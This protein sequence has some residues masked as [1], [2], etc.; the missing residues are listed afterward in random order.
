M[1]PTIVGFVV[2]A[3]AMSGALFGLWLARRIPDHELDSHSRDSIKLAV[4]LIATMTALVLGLV[5]A[6]AKSTFDS[7]SEAV[8]TSAIDLLTLDRTLARY[9]PEAAEIRAELKR[10]AGI[11]LELTWPSDSSTASR[12]EVLQHASGPEEIGNRILA[13]VPAEEV[14]TQL[15]GSAVAHAERMLEARWFLVSGTS[16][17]VPLPFLAV[18]ILWIAVS[19]TI[20]G[21]LSP[22]NRTVIGAF[23]ACALSVGTAMFLILEMDGPFDGVLTVSGDPMRRAVE[24][25]GS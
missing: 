17:S 6:S 1:N 13:L 2:F 9:G 4:G 21:M 8:K 16:G 20:Y 5:T 10:A 23:A 12:Q 22:S 15:K 24:Q 19:F 3:V 18:L 14:Q 7:L 25:L 11:R